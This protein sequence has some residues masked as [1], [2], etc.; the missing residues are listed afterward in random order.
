MNTIVK[1]NMTIPLNNIKKIE[2]D[3]E[4][5][6]ITYEDGTKR[7]VNKDMDPILFEKDYINT[8]DAP[9]VDHCI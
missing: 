1:E 3:K 7:I 8:N 4:T 6:L 5:I 9:I 2:I